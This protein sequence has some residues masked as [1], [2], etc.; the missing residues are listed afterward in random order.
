MKLN[1]LMM[2]VGLVVFSHS[3]WAQAQTPSQQWRV[4]MGNRMFAPRCDEIGDLVIGGEDGKTPIYSCRVGEHWQAVKGNQLYAPRCARMRHIWWS[5]ENREVMYTCTSGAIFAG[6]QA[7]PGSPW[8]FRYVKEDGGLCSPSDSSYYD[9]NE[10]LVNE[11][12][13]RGYDYIDVRPRRFPEGVI[14]LS[15]QWAP[16]APPQIDTS[17]VEVVVRVSPRHDLYGSPRTGSD[18]TL[19]GRSGWDVPRIPDGMPSADRTSIPARR[20]AA[21][22]C[23]DVTVTAY[24]GQAGQAVWIKRE[25]D[26]LRVCVGKSLGKA[27]DDTW[28]LDYADGMLSYFARADGNWRLVSGTREAPAFANIRWHEWVE[29]NGVDKR[30]YIATDKVGE[31]TEAVYGL[32]DGQ[33][34]FRATKPVKMLRFIPAA[35]AY[36]FAIQG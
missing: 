20:P 18:E 11:D 16:P 5:P 10:K 32:L 23:D 9:C 29:V 14:E 13:M 22:S 4:Q 31:S 12:H 8:K 25:E 30:A 24:L 36:V 34:L 27:W 6:S 35:G 7:Q 19:P 17:D 26:K 2:L 21:V 28:D 3:T 33:Q 15:F 1:L